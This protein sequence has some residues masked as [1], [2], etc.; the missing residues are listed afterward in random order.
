MP[1]RIRT[2]LTTALSLV[3]LTV[4]LAS[5]A[6][7]GDDSNRSDTTTTTRYKAATASASTPKRLRERTIAPFPAPGDTSAPSQMRWRMLN[8]PRTGITTVAPLPPPVAKGQPS[9]TSGSALPKLDSLLQ[10]RVEKHQADCDDEFST[11]PEPVFRV[12]PVSP[13]DTTTGGPKRIIKVFALVSE[14][15][16]VEAAQATPPAN[17]LDSA[18]VACVRQ[19]RFKPALHCGHAYPVWVAIPIR[20][21][22]R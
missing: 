16:L 18:A 10:K 8:L 3:T 6:F 2:V 12:D 15:G 17:T 22:G 1:S 19:W 4:P 11:L 20:F 21:D 9:G 14:V 5:D 13:P 7:A